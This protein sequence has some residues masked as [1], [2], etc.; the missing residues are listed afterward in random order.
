MATDKQ[1][2]V[3]Q[4][5]IQDSARQFAQSHIL[6]HVMEWDESQH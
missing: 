1:T 4:Q 5:I 6:P 3:D 2:L